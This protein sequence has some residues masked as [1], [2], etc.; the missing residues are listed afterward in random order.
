MASPIS[1]F[2]MER[3]IVIVV[4]DT[5]RRGIV[6]MTVIRVRPPTTTHTTTITPTALRCFTS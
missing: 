6:T 2:A 4:D 5:I 3:R 1:P